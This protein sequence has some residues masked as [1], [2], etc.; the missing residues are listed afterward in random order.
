MRV[1]IP[2]R[3]IKDNEQAIRTH[4]AIVRRLEQVPGVTAV[5]VTSAITM[6]GYDSNDPIFVE[7]FPSPE[8]RIPALRRFKCVDGSYFT[9]DGQPADRRPR[10]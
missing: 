3:S 6:D 7:D 9:D 8:G 2:E 1:S 5:G 10:C 4:E